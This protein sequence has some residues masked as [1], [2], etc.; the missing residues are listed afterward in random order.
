MVGLGVESKRTSSARSAGAKQLSH[1]GRRKADLYC[2]ERVLVTS[3]KIP[4]VRLRNE[5]VVR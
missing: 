1:S 3:P 4:V 2:A 5:N